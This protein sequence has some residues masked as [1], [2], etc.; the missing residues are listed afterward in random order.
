MGNAAVSHLLSEGPTDAAGL[1]L[2]DLL[3]ASAETGQDLS[4]FLPWRASATWT[5]FAQSWYRVIWTERN[6][7]DDVS[8][9]VHDVGDLA[10]FE[11]VGIDVDAAPAVDTTFAGPEAAEASVEGV[12]RDARGP[13][14]T[15]PSAMNTW[16]D[17]LERQTDSGRQLTSAEKDFLE[18]VHDRPIPG[19]RIHEGAFARQAS[20]EINARAFTIG[21]DVWMGEDVDLQDP[22]GAE[23]LAHEITHVIQNALGRGGSDRPVSSPGDASEREAEARGREAR[24]MAAR[25]DWGVTAPA[26]VGA[27]GRLL[28]DRMA[29]HLPDATRAAPAALVREGLRVLCTSRATA[30]IAALQEVLR[31]LDPSRS[32]VREAAARLEDARAAVA[33]AGADP[34]SLAALI[35]I[36]GAPTASELQGLQSGFAPYPTFAAQAAEL[37]TALGVAAELEAPAA[38]LPGITGLDA[39]RA[40]ATAA[41]VDR[42]S[43][44]LNLSPD[45]VDIRA[46]AAAS[47]RL[48]AVGAPGLFEGGSIF[49]DPTVFDPG[50]T[51]GAS[52]LAHEMVHA[53]QADLPAFEGLGMDPGGLAEAEAHVA[54]S[55]LASG[56]AFHDVSMGL[57]EGH[58]AAKDDLV[59][60]SL[61]N[62][63]QVFSGAAK[64]IKETF[65][66]QDGVSNT[67]DK[68]A[69]QNRE[70]KLSQ[71]A[72][73]VDGIAD[74]IGD[75][76]A[77]D[78]LCDAADEASGAKSAEEG[79]SKA[80]GSGKVDTTG[81]LAR[82][83]ASKPYA[84]LCKMWQG[85]K[86]GGEDSDSMKAKFENEFDGRGFW[87]STEKAFDIVS[88]NAKRDAKPEAAAEEGKKNA[89]AAKA[90]LGD[91]KENATGDKAGAKTKAGEGGSGITAGAAGG[92]YSKFL[93]SSVEDEVPKIGSFETM[94]S[95]DDDMMATLTGKVDEYNGFAVSAQGPDASGRTDQILGT[96]WTN[97]SA[98][99]A[100]SFTDQFI[101]TMV[102]DTLGKGGDKLLE[103]ATKGKVGGAAAPMIGPL[104]GLGK[105][106]WS[107]WD[108]DGFHAD[109]FLLSTTGAGKVGDGLSSI[110]KMSET[111]GGLS[112]CNGATDVIGV[113]FAA[114]ADFFQGLRDLADGL[115]SL[116]GTLSALCYIVGGVLILVGIATA[117]LGWGIGLITAGN[118]LVNAG[119]ILA[120][121]NT[122]LGLLVIFLSGI[123]TLF[124]TI[125][126][127][128]VPAELYQDQL[129]GVGTA[130]NNFGEKTGAKA[131]DMTANKMKDGVKQYKDS[132]AAGQK[133][134]DGEKK[135]EGQHKDAQAEMDAKNKKLEDV[136]KKLDEE[137]KKIKDEDETKKA[138]ADDEKKKKTDDGDETGATTKSTIKQKISKAF[139]L[140]P[141]V[142]DL[143]NATGDLKDLV[144]S[145]R[146]KDARQKAAAQAMRPEVA[147]AILNN[148]DG[149]LKAHAEKLKALETELAAAEKAG[150]RDGDIWALEAKLKKSQAEFEEGKKD[151]AALKA[152]VEKVA[153][154]DR[155]LAEEKRIEDENKK[156]KKKGE[157]E[158]DSPI[159]KEVSDRKKALSDADE[160]VKKADAELH[161][162]KDE[163]DKKLTELD[164]KLKDAEAKAPEIEK[165]KQTLSAALNGLDQHV[166][167]TVVLKGGEGKRK[168]TDANVR[169][170]ESDGLIVTDG[171][172]GTKK[173]TFSEVFGPASIKRDAAKATKAQRN[174]ESLE[175]APTKIKTEIDKTKGDRAALEKKVTDAKTDKEKAA[176]DLEL[177]EAKK[178]RME[179]QAQL[180]S[181]L[182]ESSSGNATG[183]VGSS[184]KFWGEG[185]TRILLNIDG[186]IASY[187]NA[188][189][190]A[191]AATVVS[192]VKEPGEEENRNKSLG[193]AATEKILGWKSESDKALQAIAAKQVAIEH[194]LELA[195]PVDIE[196]TK[197]KRIAAGEHFNK[198]KSAHDAALQAYKAEQAVEALSKETKALADAGKPIQ[199]AS[200]SMVNP[201]TKSKSDEQQRNAIIGGTDPNAPKQEEGSGGLIGDLIMKL[202][203]H[204]DGMDKQPSAGGKG[205]GTAIEDG[206]KKGK[207]DS[208]KN[209]D[210]AQ[211]M[212]DQQ[213]QFLDEAISLRQAQETNVCENIESMDQKYAE[214]QAIK[215]EI[216]TVK[217]KALAEREAEKAEVEKNASSFNSDYTAL[218]AWGTDHDLRMAAVAGAGSK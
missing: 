198:Y 26:G 49:L 16:F 38:D 59:G 98:N 82:V 92:D 134:T 178:E 116:A 45:A 125:A 179:D 8:G 189:A 118:W 5:Q 18:A 10:G 183:G 21:T 81:P 124:R 185:L 12:A 163:H 214:E 112:K 159:E 53:A 150:L 52:L 192:S 7:D 119:G 1:Y 23:L 79:E 197:K 204:S 57:P 143:R 144:A 140:V 126:A 108:K 168:T 30:E 127:F 158:L 188:G 55:A 20:A 117:W 155:A 78:D 114:G 87:G 171:K 4:A 194:A 111:L 175:G 104:I 43:H 203:S 91:T 113:L 41:L 96:L 154:T 156:R 13:D 72:D 24:T 139:N 152:E 31:D 94:T 22:S 206:Q 95:V 32:D 103:L 64:S 34:A 36:G 62:L 51:A 165:S 67:A 146:N 137:A 99:F 190:L 110:G 83:K 164:G 93:G 48:S 148:L 60:D 101:D 106:V 205:G 97:F 89:E 14:I 69:T 71:Y 80:A 129:V 6:R 174:I 56:G 173:V 100:S 28:A 29:S 196:E 84:E 37:I 73:G 61:R 109:K 133:G 25:G 88:S 70:E 47:S 54:G 102:W 46:D 9:A 3:S 170:V 122:A 191:A 195:P 153:E 115:A 15:D 19:T 77:F 27:Q 217:A 136:Q 147:E 75:L 58:V 35:G 218:N 128:M 182:R 105:E 63:L 123:T 212:S 216:Q 202:A 74:Q 149:K 85:A 68:N 11:G 161:G 50:T 132:R 201:L 199:T 66:T 65:G 131:G 166:G 172:G 180:N 162:K 42:L 86:E 193:Q 211:S 187:Q 130:A 208:K 213:R 107:A 17:R 142:K 181:Y 2:A 121:I 135:G 40:L 215:A 167:K 169:G 160:A 200:Q 151:I 138:A 157:K 120:R 145:V 184:F 209:V 33:T 207:E 90:K 76:D 141:G 44:A 186:I 39:D 176:K 177:A 210:N